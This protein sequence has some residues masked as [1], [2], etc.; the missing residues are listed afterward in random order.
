M[1][2]LLLED[3]LEEWSGDHCIDSREVPGVLLANRPIRT[4]HPDLM[5]LTATILHEFGVRAP[6]NLRGDSVF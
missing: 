4:A 6:R 2:A 1:P 5:D 3:N